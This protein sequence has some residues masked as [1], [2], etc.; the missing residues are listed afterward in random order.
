MGSEPKWPLT[1]G[2][3]GNFYGMTIGGGSGTMF[4]SDDQWDVDHA[5]SLLPMGRFRIMCNG[6][7]LGN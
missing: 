3:D 6:L 1:L 4:H 2:N 5:V 7:T